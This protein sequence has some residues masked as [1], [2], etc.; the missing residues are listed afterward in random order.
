MIVSKEVDVLK[1][2]YRGTIEGNVIHLEETTGFS[3]GTHALVTLK[4]LS[5]ATQEDIQNRQLR[6]LDKGFSLGKKLYT[7]REDLYAR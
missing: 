3:V 4:T 7:N 6:L 1:K 5:E 2:I